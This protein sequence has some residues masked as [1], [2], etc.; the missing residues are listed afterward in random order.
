MLTDISTA[1]LVQGC[2]CF[3][4]DIPQCATGRKRYFWVLSYRIFL[5]AN[6][7]AE[8]RFCMDHWKTWLRIQIWGIGITYLFI[9]PWVKIGTGLPRD[10]AQPNSVEG[11]LEQVAQGYVKLSFEYRRGW[12]FHDLQR[13]LPTSAVLWFSLV[14]RFALE[15]EKCKRSQ[16]SRP[17]PGSL[18]VHVYSF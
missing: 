15:E 1:Q 3:H 8:Y 5:S 14:H 11:H 10:I 16:I 18:T 2:F 12:R 4:S 13:C 6:A 9:L 17:L 7:N